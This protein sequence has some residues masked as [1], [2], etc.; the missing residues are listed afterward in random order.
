MPSRIISKSSECVQHTP[1]YPTLTLTCSA[2]SSNFNPAYAGPAATRAP[3]ADCSNNCFYPAPQATVLSWFQIPISATYTAET[4]I[5]IVN[6]KTSN[7]RTITISNT[8][9]DFDKIVTPTNLNS[10]GTV[11]ASV[12]DKDGSTRIV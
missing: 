11:T 5:V 3:L 4:V 10:E 1:S 2:F 6:R 7:T 12:I 8:E 9:I